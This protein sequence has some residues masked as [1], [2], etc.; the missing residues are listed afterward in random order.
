VNRAT[1][2]YVKNYMSVAAVAYRVVVQ[3]ASKRTL[4]TLSVASVPVLAGTDP[5]AAYAAG[6]GQPSWSPVIVGFG[7][8]LTIPASPVTH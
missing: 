7:A 5:D 1:A 8:L 2:S 6:G 3:R 4:T